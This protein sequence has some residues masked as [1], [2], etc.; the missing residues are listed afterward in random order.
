MGNPISFDLDESSIN[1]L[2][3]SNR[4][5]LT[6]AAPCISNWKLEGPGQKKRR[7]TTHRKTGRT[8]KP[9]SSGMGE[10]H[11]CFN[12][13]NQTDYWPLDKE[14]GVARGAPKRKRQKLWKLLC[15]EW[16]PPWH[17]KTPMVH[18]VFVIG[19][20]LHMNVRVVVKA[21]HLKCLHVRSHTIPQLVTLGIL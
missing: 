21:V 6:K 17:F 4:G 19:R 14:T 5:G 7:N 11:A 1:N 9:H 3:Q 2:Q 13:N 18:L 8:M 10:N 16:S 12:E 20:E 15:F